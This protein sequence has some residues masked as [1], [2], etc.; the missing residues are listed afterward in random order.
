LLGD[1]ANPSRMI[2]AE[3]SFM[4]L[5]RLFLVGF[6]WAWLLRDFLNT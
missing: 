3:H 6:A 1:V 5:S 4:A 2:V